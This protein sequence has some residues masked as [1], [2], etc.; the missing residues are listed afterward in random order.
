MYREL[1][2]VDIE[3][4]KK[5]AR[6]KLGDCR[7]TNDI[8]GT[9]IF[10]ILSLYARVIYYPLGDDAPWGFTRISGSTNDAE[11]E[12]PFV[13]LNTS[14]S[15]PCQVFAAAHELYHIWYEQ[16]PDMLPG[17]LLDEDDKEINE[18]KANRFAAE[19]LVDEEILCQEIRTYK[20]NRVSIKE[21]LQLSE[22]FTV[23]YKAMVKRLH[24]TGNIDGIT[25]EQL[26]SEPD[27]SISQYRKRYAISEGEADNRIAI[28][29]LVDLSVNAYELGFITF[30]KLEY[31]LGIC[32]LEPNDLGILKKSSCAFP[33][34]KE[35]DEIMEE[36]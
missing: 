34:E 26:L 21:V 4:V 24:E 16:K 20:I 27:E 13:A 36:D 19:F 22:L 14:I 9:Q 17:N 12:K 28:D 8:I 29:N 32:N 23:P 18:K 10:N 5:R 30:E 2:N 6:E 25:K 3:E 11:L 7:K 33:S 35:L 1:N 31:L 15:V